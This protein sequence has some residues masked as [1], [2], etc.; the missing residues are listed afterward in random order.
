ME[1]LLKRRAYSPSVFSLDNGQSCL[2]SHPEI[3]TAIFR[4]RQGMDN[5]G[6]REEFLA[7]IPKVGLEDPVRE[8]M[9]ARQSDPAM[10]AVEVQV[11]A[12]LRH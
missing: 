6:H 4:F 12:Y 9:K 8:E 11:A 7:V 3:V 1:T 10:R 2:Y 5:L